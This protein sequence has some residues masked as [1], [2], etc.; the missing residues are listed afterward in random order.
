MVTVCAR[1]LYATRLIQLIRVQGTNIQLL[2]L[3]PLLQR[4]VPTESAPRKAPSG[5][6]PH[7]KKI[8]NRYG[9]R[10]SQ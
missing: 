8:K 9:R 10:A 4:L 6:P 1:T 2:C 5:Q 7:G 3:F